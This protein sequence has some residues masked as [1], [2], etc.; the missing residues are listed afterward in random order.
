MTL[1][2][3]ILSLALH[4]QAVDKPSI[5]YY[6]HAFTIRMLG[7]STDVPLEPPAPTAPGFIA[8][9]KNDAW[10]VWDDR[11]LTVRKGEQSLTT[12]MPEI[13][14]SPRAFSRAEI[15][16]TLE[17]VKNGDCTKEASALSGAKRIGKDVFFLLRWEDKAGKPWAEALVQVDLSIDKPRPKLLGRFGGLSTASKSIDDK[18][19]VQR[20][21]LAIVE[22]AADSWGVSTYDATEKQFHTQAMGGTLISFDSVRESRAL[23]V[24]TSAYGTTIAGRLNIDTGTRKILYEGHE[25][26]RFL[27]ASSPEIVLAPAGS[28]TKL[29]NCAT[30]A[31][32]MIPYLVEAKRVGKN[33]LLWTPAEDPTAAWLMSPLTW[34]TLT[35]WRYQ[36]R[37][38]LSN[39]IQ[40]LVA[41]S[42]L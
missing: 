33:I 17:R 32:R 23:F 27:D 16:R 30:G 29:I 15:L 20:G 31:V 22:H 38:P 42:V 35:T 39:A 11:G 24:E 18:L 41:Q 14:V 3:A 4:L 26:A 10:A 36:E 7:Q 37:G 12:K 9:R 25:R 34:E 40:F 1:T 6:Q 8:F 13:A 19:Q 21:E 28:K 2:A 5:Q